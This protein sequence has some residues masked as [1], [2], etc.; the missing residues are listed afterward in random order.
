MLFFL[1]G[2]TLPFLFENRFSWIGYSFLAIWSWAFS[3]LTFI[4]YEFSGRE[5]FRK[6]Q[7]YI[8]VS[9]H[10][11]FLDLPGL[12]MFI[13]GEFRPLAKRELLI[14]PIFRLIATGSTKIVDPSIRARVKK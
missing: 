1:P 10:T 14:I 11:S 8:Y 7:V 4:R 6:G 12:A 5:N 9:N 13:R 2:L 3:M